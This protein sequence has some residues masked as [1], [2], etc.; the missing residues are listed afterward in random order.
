M[1]GFSKIVGQEHIKEHLQGAIQSRMVSHAYILQGEAGT[2][3]KLIADTFAMTLQCEQGDTEPCMVCHSCK[4][5]AS[6]NHPDI[7]RLIP[8]R[9][10]LIKVDEIRRQIVN[11]VGIKPYSGPYKVYIVPNADTMNVMAQNALLKTLEEP[12][13]YVVILLLC[14]NAS[15]LLETIQSR[16]IRLD[17]RP[18]KDELVKEYLM[19]NVH[20]PD[21]QASICAA[22]AKG[23][24]G[25]AMSL[26]KNDDF[27]AIREETAGLFKDLPNM[28]IAQMADESK[29]IANFSA[30][31]IEFLDY[32]SLWYRDILMYK[33]TRK[34]ENLLHL[35]DRHMIAATAERCS[36]EG[37]KQILSLIESTK[38]RINANVNPEMALELL[39]LAMKEN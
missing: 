34:Y 10:D 36:Y 18:L 23:S 13:S 21:Y 30:G 39:L 12:P 5:A 1:I 28:D 15:L 24:I 32:L 29:K 9:E 31:V 19:Q 33:A 14:R 38:D 37:I 35:E 22:F 11:D 4:Q 6:N 17:I 26:L 16:C 3:K 8:E 2:G 25:R 7:R 20:I 27:E